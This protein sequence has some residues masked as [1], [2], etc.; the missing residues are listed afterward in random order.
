LDS[1]ENIDGENIDGEN[2]DGKDD[3][4]SSSNELIKHKK[5]L[6]NADLKDCY[7][8]DLNAYFCENCNKSFLTMQGLRSHLIN[9][10]IHKSINNVNF[11]NI[12]KIKVFIS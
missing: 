4:L 12:F 10:K 6:K 2:F 1:L 3:A 11:Y 7:R 9:A 5:S 8:L